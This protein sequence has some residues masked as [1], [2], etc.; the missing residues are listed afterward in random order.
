MSDIL[1]AI[2]EFV[3]RP[4]DASTVSKVK[5]FFSKAS[6]RGW[7]VDER[8]LG[9]EAPKAEWSPILAFFAPVGYRP[10]FEQE[11]LFLVNDGL[12]YESVMS[13][14]VHLRKRLVEQKISRNR[15]PS[16][17]E[18]EPEISQTLKE[19]MDLAASRT[20][21]QEVGEGSE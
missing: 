1:D 12:P 20:R 5:K 15:K 16:P 21:E 18:M 19:Q 11:I 9:T 8:V 13:M 10:L 7:V 3:N 14:P 2:T 4:R 6:S 17:T